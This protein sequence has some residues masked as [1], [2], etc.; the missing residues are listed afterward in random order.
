LIYLDSNIFISAA[1]YEDE[2]GNNSRKIIKE[3]RLGNYE[4]ST[5]TL[6][7][8]EVYWI[9]KREKDKKNALR[10]VKSM[11]KMKNL[12]F[13]SVD[14]SILWKTYEILDENDLGPRDS[15]HLS[16]ALESGSE[17]MIS[18]DSDFEDIDL[19]ESININDFVKR[20]SE[21]K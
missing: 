10:I 17:L 21:K 6:T 19:I 1:L 12:K 13:I 3:I 18:E 11:L 9:V 4:A 2:V 5:S 20:T 7:F 14:K 8:D 16:C 15:I